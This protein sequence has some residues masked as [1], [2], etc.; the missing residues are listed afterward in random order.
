MTIPD[1][2]EAARLLRSLEPPP[3]FLRHACAVADVSAW[4]AARSAAGGRAVDV[5]LVEAA[6]LLHDVDKLP[7]ARAPAHLR[8]G[9][10]AA[11]WL[12]ARGMAELAPAV[13]DHPVTRLAEPAYE[14]WV[15]AASPEALILAYADKRAGQRLEPMAERFASWRRRYPSGP[16]E[17]VTRGLDGPPA[18][19]G[20]DD[21]VA[22]LVHR[23][24]LALERIVCDA[25]GVVPA[26]VARL[27]WSR[28]ALREAA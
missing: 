16:A 6:A 2:R 17:D 28:R 12:E 9:D 5:A 13:R 14:R 25:A 22:A 19:R 23:R 8:H 7:S 20:W 1:R 21:E 11:A 4:L 27:R 3:W 24:A 10:G 18:G 26:E 15:D